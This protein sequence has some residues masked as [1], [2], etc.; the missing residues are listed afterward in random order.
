ARER[1]TAAV[2]VLQAA[3]DADA[4]LALEQLATLEVFA[5][6]PDAGRLSA[7]ALFLGQD[8][9]VRPGLL[10]SLLLMRGIYVSI[11][12]RRPQAM[13]YFREAARLATLDGDTSLLGRALVNLADTQAVTD[14]AAAAEAARTAAGHL[15]R[16]GAR[17]ILAVATMN[18]AEALLQLGDWDAAGE[19]LTQ[20]HTQLA[21][22]QVLARVDSLACYRGWLVALRGDTATAETMLAGLRDVRVSED[23]QD[24]SMVE[25]AE[26]FTAAARGESGQA[27]RHTRAVLSHAPALGISHEYQRWSWP[28]AARCAHDLG[29]RTATREL[30]A[31]IDSHPPGHLAPML[32]AERDLVRVRLAAS[33]GDDA[34]P[35]AFA[36]AITGLREHSTPYHLAHGL[37]DQAGYLI[38]RGDD[39]AAA[40]AVTEARDIGQRLRCQPLLDRAAAMTPEEPRISA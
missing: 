20:L 24:R 19:V 31:M 1:L 23:P 36:A 15:R 38:G 35:A 11:G 40:A 27:L 6:S 2:E 4:V 32:R 5:G 13:A 21:D 10:S 7:E 29:D 34:D 37:L 26:A 16:T 25:T 9:D 17:D 30:L 33:D 39:S 22:S 12:Q 14:P 18:L 3:P 8:L 28:L